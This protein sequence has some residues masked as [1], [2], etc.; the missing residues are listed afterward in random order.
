MKLT[1]IAKDI[2]RKRYLLKNNK[3]KVIETPAGMF[4]RVAGNIAK[5]DLKYNKKANV[6]KVGKDFFDAMIGLD[7]LPNSPTLMNAGTKLGQLSACFAVP[8]EDSIEGVFDALKQMALIHKSG[9]GVGYS[10]SRIRPKSDLV[11]SSKGRASGPVSFMHI[12][13]KATEVIKL[14]GRR[15]GANIAI[16]SVSHPDIIEFVE[17]KKNNELQ[18]FNISVAVTDEFVKAVKKDAYFSLVNPRTGKTARRVKARLIFDKIVENAWKHGDPGIIFIDE[19]NRKNTLKLG[20]I[21]STNP[22]SEV[23]LYPF[24]SC[25]LG[26]INLSNIVNDGI[27]DWD[28]LQRIVRLGVHFLDNVID[29][30]IFPLPEIEEATKENRK[31]GLGI[32]GFAEFLIKLGIAYDSE[33]AVQIAERVMKF[34]TKEARNKSVELGRERGSFPNFRVSVFYKRFKHMR[35]ATVTSIAPTGTISMIANTSSGIEPL[36]AISFERLVMG[37]RKVFEVNSLFKESMKIKGMWTKKIIK[38]ID[39]YSSVQKIK[40]I[41]E[42][43]RR[44]FVTSLDIKPEWHL[45]VQAAFQRFTDN[46]ISKTV[47][48]PSS[49]SINDVKKVFMGAYEMKCKGITVYKYGS[50]ENQVLNVC[51]ECK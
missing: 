26:S 23:P 10:F 11:V 9:G 50:I 24:E 14:G 25:N 7:F 21:E 42:D 34:I 17:S 48:L 38:A 6:K 35:N 29:A 13:D 46:A 15:R 4:R 20:K 32:M 16:L 5:V 12:F 33:E 19:V 40:D 18:N 1:S 47:N 31:I 22:C 36:F 27:I 49:A 44:V 45:R 43:I 2:L 39:H 37:R 3:G 28:K 8:I 51:E 41:P 30:N